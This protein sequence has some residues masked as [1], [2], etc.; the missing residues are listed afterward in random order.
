MSGY[1][2]ILLSDMIE[3]LGEDRAKEILSEFSCPLNSDVEKF[4]KSTSIEFAKQRI[5]ATHLLF[6]DYKGKLVLVGYFTVA[7]KTFKVVK[8]CLSKTKQKQISKFGTYDSD[9]KSYNIPAPLIAQLGKNFTNGYNKLITGDELLSIA[10]ANVNE[11]QLLLSGKIVY[12]ECE[13]K[14]KLID[15]YESNGF[16]KFGKRKLDKDEDV[17][18]EYLCQ[19]LK[20]L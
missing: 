6:C 18:G 7:L 5:A 10:C 13:E 2:K 8:S 9:T 4:L 1:K 19:M 12:L 11:C 20:Y 3:E 14:Q 15:F 16:C 17:D